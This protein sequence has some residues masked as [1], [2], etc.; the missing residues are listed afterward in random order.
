MDTKSLITDTLAN[1]LRVHLYPLKDSGNSVT[2]IMNY[3]V[4]V[5]E[6]NKDIEGISHFVEHLMF[7]KI[8][9]YGTIDKVFKQMYATDHN[10]TSSYNSTCYNISVHPD[11]LESALWLEAYRMQHFNVDKA[12]F[13]R[14]KNIILQEIGEH[15]SDRH[16]AILLDWHRHLYG[17]HH[18]Y[19][20][21]VL[22]SHREQFSNISLDDAIAHQARYYQPMNAS[23]LILGNFDPEQALALVHKQ[24]GDL[25]NNGSLIQHSPARTSPHMKFPKG[26]II[27]APNHSEELDTLF[28]S[29]QASP[30]FSPNRAK[31]ALLE[32]I[33]EEEAGHNLHRDLIHRRKI[34]DFL[35]LSLTPNAYDNILTFD[36]QIEDT[37]LEPDWI[38]EQ[39]RTSFELLLKRGIQS[40]AVKSTQ[41]STQIDEVLN[42]DSTMHIV[43]TWITWETAGD[44]LKYGEYKESYLNTKTKDLNDYLAHFLN[45]DNWFVYHHAK[46]YR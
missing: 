20:R 38:F 13:E 26:Q 4:S 34:S 43:D 30:L 29:F 39:F 14:E 41:K 19:A 25:K 23:L 15:Y 16:S 11:N 24:F 32:A 45:P 28:I 8:E 3:R 22:G 2:T 6:E 37:L 1:G 10:A 44:A 40:S 17:Q 35:N 18:G 46:C 31:E 12:L 9:P 27:Q 21:E 7:N 36:T 5:L 33:L 42:Y